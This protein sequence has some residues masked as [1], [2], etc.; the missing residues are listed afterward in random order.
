[1]GKLTTYVLIMSGSVLLFY[2]TGIL[3][4]T[5]NSTFLN[6]LM[7]PESLQT[8]GF[9]IQATAVLQGVVIGGLFIG[10]LAFGNVE[11]LFKAAFTLYLLNLL[12]D[13]IVIFNAIRSA[14]TI[15]ALLF[16]VPILFLFFMTILEWWGKH[17]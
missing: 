17:D 16:F 7:S 14:N 13:F 12:W 15:L 8:S 3:G 4:D 1:M 5:P 10:A 6:L 11:A 2:F 9:V